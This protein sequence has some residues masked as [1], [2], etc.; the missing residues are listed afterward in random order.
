MRGRHERNARQT[1]YP[2]T[3]PSV[4]VTL[5]VLGEQRAIH[6][7]RA[8]NHDRAGENILA[9]RRLE[10]T[11]RRDDRHATTRDVVIADH[12]ADAAKVV[13]VAVGV[14]HGTDGPFSQVHT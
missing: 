5:R 8:A 3:E 10:E 14:D 12:S 6:I 13:G 7:H 9:Y 1:G 11:L 2:F 4:D